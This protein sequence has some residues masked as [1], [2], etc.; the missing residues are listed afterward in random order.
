MRAIDRLLFLKLAPRQVRYL[1]PLDYARAT[2]LARSVLDQLEREFVVGPPVTIHLP[3]PDLLA[4]V[5]AMGRECLASG[6][7]SDRTG[8]TTRELVAAEV[9]RI[10]Q[11]PYCFDT[12][13]AM[14]HAFGHGD[15]FTD[16]ALQPIARWAAA[17]LSPGAIAP[18]AEADHPAL[19]GTA[20]CFHYLNRMANVFLD[21][22]PFTFHH[23]AIVKMSGRILRGLVTAQQVT[24]GQFLVASSAPL[25][26]EFAWA[27][28]NAN[29]AGGLSRFAAAA[30][31][32][33]EESIAPDVRARVIAQIG[34][35]N[36]EPPA[37]G[38]E[39]E[40]SAAERLALQTAL[41]SWQVDKK[42]IGQF[43]RERQS[44]RDLINTAAWGSYIAA[45]RIGS[46]L[47]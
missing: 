19:F 18:V 27:E 22:A 12:H 45:R 20:V 46:W 5:W 30:E 40:G 7:N 1:A 8:R 17:T 25:P 26:N 21:P 34:E 32:A 36:G 4:G 44:D 11:C 38:W 24:P 33:G 28:P 31:A 37:L 29:I 41:A 39:P 15:A 47:R 3:N 9:S 23:S 2:G 14:L 10:N 35:W 6:S 16:P 42:L 43:R 13:G